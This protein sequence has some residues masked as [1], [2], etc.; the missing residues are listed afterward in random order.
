MKKK[1]KNY[2]KKEVHQL[3]TKPIEFY[4]KKNQFNNKLANFNKNNQLI[5][6][7]TSKLKT[8]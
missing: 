5:N 1:Y 3:K 4:K 6:G 7:N 2:R 8:G